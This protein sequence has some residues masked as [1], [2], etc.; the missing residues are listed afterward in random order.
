MSE[1]PSIAWLMPRSAHT[2]IGLLVDNPHVP[3]MPLVASRMTAR[4]GK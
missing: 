3:L 2:L 1:S 4:S